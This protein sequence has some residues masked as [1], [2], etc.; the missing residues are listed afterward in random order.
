MALVAAL[1]AAPWRSLNESRRLHLW[2]ATSA[3]L[4]LLWSLKTGIKQGLEFHLLGAT[5]FTLMFGWPLAVIGG[6][7][8]LLALTL[9]QGGAFDAFAFRE[10]ILVTLPILSSHVVWRLTERRLPN[11]LFIFFFVSGFGNGAVAMLITGLATTAMYASAS[12]YPLDYLLS[13][14]LPYFVLMA[15]PEAMLTGMAVTLMAVYFP[16]MI[17][18]FDD[19]RYLRRR[20]TS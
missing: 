4:A 10:L 8:A 1:R 6:C 7:M 14:Y 11:H 20:G 18:A 5:A 13:E 3:T 19:E 2:F 15:Y 17:E 16:W 12:V 9:Q